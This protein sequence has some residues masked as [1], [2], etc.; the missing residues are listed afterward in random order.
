MHHGP[1]CMYKWVWGVFQCPLQ[2]LVN[3]AAIS[4]IGFY[5]VLSTYQFDRSC[6]HAREV[7]SHRWQIQILETQVPCAAKK[8]PQSGALEHRVPVSNVYLYIYT[9][10]IYKLY[11]IWHMTHYNTLYV[12]IHYIYIYKMVTITIIQWSYHQPHPRHREI[13]AAIVSAFHRI[14]NDVGIVQ[15]HLE[16]PWSN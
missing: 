12:S 3:L 10:D 14:K 13:S 9:Y 4:V 2:S 11:G 5:H 6:H 15:R 8:S 1:V 16:V 7:V